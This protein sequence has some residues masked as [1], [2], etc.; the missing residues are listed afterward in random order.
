MGKLWLGLVV[1]K[2]WSMKRSITQWQKLSYWSF[3]AVL[4]CHNKIDVSIDI[5]VSND[6]II[7]G[8]LLSDV[9]WSHFLFRRCISSSSSKSVP[10]RPFFSA[11]VDCFVFFLAPFAFSMMD[12]DC[13][14]VVRPS[15][16]TFCRLYHGE[17]HF[18]L[19]LLSMRLFFRCDASVDRI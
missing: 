19:S 6:L 8:W 14:V 17:S 13:W 7:R 4:H 5:Y 11:M 12:V 10:S 1:M 9:A 2:S 18:L 15:K 3:Q 16:Q